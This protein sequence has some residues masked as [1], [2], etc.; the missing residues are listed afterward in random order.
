MGFLSKIWQKTANYIYPYK[1]SILLKW[2]EG[3]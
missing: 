2:Q 1:P 3:K